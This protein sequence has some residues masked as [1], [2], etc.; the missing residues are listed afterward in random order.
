[1]SKEEGI[2]ATA[3][4]QALTRGWELCKLVDMIANHLHV[5]G[6]IPADDTLNAMFDL[7]EHTAECFKEGYYDRAAAEERRAAAVE[8]TAVST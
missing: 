5:I 6:V 3:N 4:E 1:M 8:E 2:S 7:A